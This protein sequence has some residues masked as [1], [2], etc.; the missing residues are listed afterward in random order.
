M[1]PLFAAEQVAGAADLQIQRGDAEAAA[2][3]AELANSREALLRDR[4]QRLLRRN[5][6]VRVRMAV[7]AA[8]AAAQLVQ[9]R[10]PVAVGAVDDHRVGVRDVEAVLDDRGGDQH[11]VF[12]VDEIEH[13]L[14]HFLFVHLPVPDGDT[15]VRDD[16]L[17]QGGDR[18]YRL[19]AIVDE[20]HLP[21][22]G[23]L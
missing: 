18:L 16:L 10:Q 11:V 9:L 3:I 19:D 23:E 6:Q 13:N 14:L 22:A 15:G 1:W 21:V 5:Q 7:G 2:Q 12:E 17:Y 8:D 20:E 4:R